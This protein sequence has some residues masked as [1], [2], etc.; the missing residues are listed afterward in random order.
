MIHGHTGVKEDRDAL[1]LTLLKGAAGLLAHGCLALTFRGPW[2]L[3]S[4]VSEPWGAM[5]D[6]EGL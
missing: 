1:G 3:Q 6:L 2:D 5:E 4:H